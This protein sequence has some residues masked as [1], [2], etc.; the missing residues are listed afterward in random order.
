MSR[1]VFFLS[2]DGRGYGD[3]ALQRLVGVGEGGAAPSLRL[4]RLLCRQAKFI[5]SREGREA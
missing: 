1:A 2:L 3:L 4:A 5:L